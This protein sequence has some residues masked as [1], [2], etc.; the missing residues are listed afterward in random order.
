MTETSQSRRNVLVMVGMHNSGTSLVANMAHELGVALGPR[1]LTRDSYAPG[2]QPKYDYWE[3]ADITACQDRLMEAIDRHWRTSKGATAIDATLWTSPAIAPFRAELAAAIRREL[4]ETG[5]QALWGVK[6]PRTVRLLPLW[7][8]VFEELQL[9]PLYVVCTRAP[10][11]VARSFARKAAVPVSWAEALWRRHYLESLT[12]TEGAPRLFVD[13]QEWF[14]HPE[15]LMDALIGFL[16]ITVPSDRRAAALALIDPAVSDVKG[17]PPPMD[18]LS[19]EIAELCRRAAAGE[20]VAAAVRALEI[21]MAEPEM[22]VQVPGSPFPGL[23]ADRAGEPCRPVRRSVALV[24][25]EYPGLGPC[26][27]I[28]TAFG[29]LGEALT[30]AG[31]AVT[32]L[33]CGAPGPRAAATAEALGRRGIAVETLPRAGSPAAAAVAVLERLKNRRLD[34][35]HVHDWMGLGGLLALAKRNGQALAEGTVLVCGT[36]GPT[37]WACEANG[38]RLTGAE[39]LEADGLERLSVA[40]ADVVASPSSYLLEWMERRGWPLPEGRH[41]VQHNLYP[42]AATSL[43]KGEGKNIVEP[44]FFG[45]LEA[46]KGVILFVEALE[47]LARRGLAPERVSFLGGNTPTVEGDA[48]AW[49]RRRL[50]TTGITLSIIEDRDRDAALDYLRGTGRLAVIPSLAENSPFTV[51]EAMM[52]GL[53]FIAAATGGIPELIAEADRER[54]LFAPVAEA[55]ADCLARILRHSVKGACPSVP[56]EVTHRAWLAWHERLPVR[57]PVPAPAVVTPA[58]AETSLREALERSMSWRLTAPLRRL[59]GTE[60]IRSPQEIYASLWWD[61]T[62]PLRLLGRLARRWRIIPPRQ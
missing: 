25:M 24:T 49:I 17:A 53:P 27:G 60:R 50:A 30:Q 34:A 44:V 6:D 47:L 7:R 36:H 29:A 48:A 51:L 61:L 33:F 41:Y 58:S 26:G 57:A 45:R 20:Q 35:V 2:E 18:P 1:V 9:A 31:H 4:T 52:E 8:Q 59:A 12:E 54:V 16:G 56:V 22:A 39:A 42:F 37:A 5:A 14:R 62:A 10:G 15:P 3:H 38:Q 11:A 43:L 55:L 21:R 46:R 32:V 19:G 40:Y 28:G 23:D 13:Y